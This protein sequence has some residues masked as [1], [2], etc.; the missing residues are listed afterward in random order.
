MTLTIKRLALLALVSMIL[1]FCGLCDVL[2]ALVNLSVRLL[3]PTK[4]F[5][6][7]QAANKTIRDWCANSSYAYDRHV[8]V[9]LHDESFEGVTRRGTGRR[10]CAWK[11]QRA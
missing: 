6:L 10:P 3:D 11:H 2:H 4:C 8:R 9:T 5:I 7:K 1:E